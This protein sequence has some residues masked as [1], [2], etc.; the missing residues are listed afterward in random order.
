MASPSSGMDDA[1]GLRA[2]NDIHTGADGIMTAP[3]SPA[4]KPFRAPQVRTYGS[5]QEITLAVGVHG[6]SDGGSGSSQK[7]QP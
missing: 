2:G 4:K 5:V 1:Q 6:N 3:N 7:T